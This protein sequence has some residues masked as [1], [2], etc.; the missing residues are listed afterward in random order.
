MR[1]VEGVSVFYSRTYT[2]SCGER[3]CC[4][5]ATV[6][7][8]RTTDGFEFN[9]FI[10]SELTLS[11]RGSGLRNATADAA[12]SNRPTEKPAVVCFRNS[13]KGLG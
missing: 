13:R 2:T 10:G 7:A 5:A 4:V 12:G 6:A 3:A 9:F 8:L 1:L 11:S